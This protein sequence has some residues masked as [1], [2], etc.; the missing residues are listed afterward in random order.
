[1]SYITIKEP[2]FNCKDMDA[3]LR[4]ILIRNMAS[5]DVSFNFTW[6]AKAALVK[7]AK[8][9][10]TQTI[11]MLIKMLP[12]T[13]PIIECIWHEFPEETMD[14]IVM[15]PIWNDEPRHSGVPLFLEDYCIKHGKALLAKYDKIPVIVMALLAN[16]NGSY[17][18]DGMKDVTAK[19]EKITPDVYVK[20]IKTVRRYPKKIKEEIYGYRSHIIENIGELV[21]T[22]KLH[23]S[24]P[25]SKEEKHELHTPDGLQT[26]V[27]V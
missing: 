15:N 21:Y 7:R 12:S 8:E 16:V 5:N 26:K 17:G 2:Q 10:T 4:T 18:T 9:I 24:L 27:S 22:G 11:E 25:E 14:K 19:G 6:R 3:R 1:M 20:Y 13:I 23:I